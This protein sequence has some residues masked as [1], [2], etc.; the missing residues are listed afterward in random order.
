VIGAFF[1]VALTVMLPAI[2]SA[3]SQAWST[4]TTMNAMS[5]QPEAA[6]HMRSLLLPAL[7]FMEALTLIAFVI[8]LLLWIKV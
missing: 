7:A 1:A 6:G 5:R 8:A 4:V 3:L 2:A